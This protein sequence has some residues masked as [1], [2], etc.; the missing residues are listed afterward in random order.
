MINKDLIPW[1][2]CIEFTLSDKQVNTM[3]RYLRRVSNF[4]PRPC[5][6]SIS[7]LVKDTWRWLELAANNSS[8]CGGLCTH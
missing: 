4:V 5:A 3:F 1:A 6:P 8:M 7:M 2:E